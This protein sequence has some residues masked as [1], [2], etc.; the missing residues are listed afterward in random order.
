MLTAAG[1]VV[2]QLSPF[3][4]PDQVGNVLAGIGL[5]TGILRTVTTKPLSEK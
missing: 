1:G 2:Q 5:V 4:P 3:I